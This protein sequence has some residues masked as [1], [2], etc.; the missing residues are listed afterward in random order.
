MT[1]ETSSYTSFPLGCQTNLTA[2]IFALM[3]YRIA[4][5]PCLNLQHSADIAVT[6]V[7]DH[8]RWIH[9][10]DQEKRTFKT[11]TLCEP[12]VSEAAASRLIIRYKY[13]ATDLWP[14]SIDEIRNKIFE[15]GMID[16]G[17]GGELVARLLLTWKRDMLF[18][19][20]AKGIMSNSIISAVVAERNPHMS[21]APPF[22]V[23][24]FMYNRSLQKLRRS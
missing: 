19:P 3:A 12:L 4:L 1:Y 14:K 13:N 20:V 16:R 5:D 7:N 24:D 15:P 10:F 23:V 8:L 2:H 17:K 11:K 22:K 6:A 18:R 21:Y 9:S